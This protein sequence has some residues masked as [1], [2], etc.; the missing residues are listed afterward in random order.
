M[1]AAAR[2]FDDPADVK[3]ALEEGLDVLNVTDNATDLNKESAAQL[4]I[5]KKAVAGLEA[6][7]YESEFYASAN[8]LERGVILLMTMMLY[9]AKYFF[10]VLP[11]MSLYP[12]VRAPRAYH[13]C[14]LTPTKHRCLP[15]CRVTATSYREP[16]TPRSLA[17]TLRPAK[18]TS[19]RNGLPA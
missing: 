1:T 12:L 5:A 15:T 18:R 9:G 13:C 8:M 14:I 19:L 7:L 17:A 16:T 6:L 4:K 10:A 2:N 11:D 3:A